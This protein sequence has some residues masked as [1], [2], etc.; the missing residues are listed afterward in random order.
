MGFT[1]TKYPTLPSKVETLVTRK[2]GEVS[3]ERE[4]SIVTEI[5]EDLVQESPPHRENAQASGSGSRAP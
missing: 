5:V 3:K 4:D 2:G 1:P